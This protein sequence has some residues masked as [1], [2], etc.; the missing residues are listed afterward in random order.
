MWTRLPGDALGCGLSDC[1]CYV[2][3]SFWCFTVWRCNSKI[4]EI[5]LEISTRTI[6]IIKDILMWHG[7]YGT[8]AAGINAQLVQQTINRWPLNG[9]VN[10]MVLGRRTSC[11][12]H[13]IV[14]INV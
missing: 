3:P 4:P 14:L 2:S 12:I 10:V 11:T 5:Q 8:N 7:I 13:C 6:N 9:L 1:D